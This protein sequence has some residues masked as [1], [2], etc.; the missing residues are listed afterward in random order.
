MNSKEGS[1]FI[2]AS[3]EFL[4]FQGK[5]RLNFILIQGTMHGNRSAKTPS[6]ANLRD[7]LKTGIKQLLSSLAIN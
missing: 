4:F 7:K 2:N 3:S 5:L 6:R 1:Y